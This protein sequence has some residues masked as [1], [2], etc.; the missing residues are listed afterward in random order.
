MQVSK[1]EQQKSGNILHLTV[2]TYANPPFAHED[3]YARARD[4]EDCSE[5][6]EH[7]GARIYAKII[8]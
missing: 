4:A 1:N 3:M 2:R 6:G 5:H 8:F 7:T